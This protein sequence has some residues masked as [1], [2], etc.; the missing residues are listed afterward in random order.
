[1]VEAFRHAR[2]PAE[3]IVD[4]V[5]ATENLM[6]LYRSTEIGETVRIS[7]P[8]LENAI[9]RIARPAGGQKWANGN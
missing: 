1:M 8:M 7:D 3:T 4:G 9:P 6:G 2:L 5:V